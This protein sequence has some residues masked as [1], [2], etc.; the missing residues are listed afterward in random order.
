VFSP[1]TVQLQSP[2]YPLPPFGVGANMAFRVEALQEIGGFNESLGA[3]TLAK[4]SE[5]TLAFTKILLTGATMVYQPSALTRHFHRPDIEGLRAQMHGYGAG[6]TGYYT[7]LV[8]DDPRLIWPLLRLVP[9]AVRDL[10]GGDSPITAALGADFP[11]G[12]IAANRRGMLSGPFRYLRGRYCLLKRRPDKGCGAPDIR[13][14]VTSTR[15][16][17]AKP[18]PG[19]AARKTGSPGLVTLEVHHQ[20]DGP[21]GVST[22]P[23]VVSS[24]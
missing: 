24:G 3:G 13:Y 4:G 11:T 15:D 21:A 22:T 1:A 9:R 19:A 2:L 17:R 12:L 23:G 5:D 7:A 6:L 10:M 16:M 18:V 8:L 20:W 14:P